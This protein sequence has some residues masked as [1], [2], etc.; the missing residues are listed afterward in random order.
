MSA[1]IG[2][3]ILAMWGLYHPDYIQ[4]KWHVFVIYIIMT[5]LCCALVMFGNR[6][7][8][9][10]QNIG[11]FVTVAGVVITVLVCAIMPSR[12][13]AGYASNAFVW[14][15]WDNQTGFSSNGFVFLA[16]LLNGAYSV[17][18]PDCVTHLA[19]EIPKP[20]VN[21]PKAI[22]AQMIVGAVTALVYLVAIFYAINSLDDILATTSSFPI[23][24]V[25]HQ[26]TNSN[27]GA[28]GLLLV[29][30]LPLIGTL[31][32]SYITVG[33]IL[34]TLARDD[35]TPLSSFLGRLDARQKNP[36]NATLACGIIVT[37]LG[38]IYLGSSTAFA[39]FVGSYVVLSTLSYLCAILPNLL[40]RR[41]YLP[42][43]PFRIPG[44]WGDVVYTLASVYIIVFIGIFCAPYALPVTAGSMNYT[45]VITVGSS[46]FVAALWVW[47]KSAGYVGPRVLL[48]EVVVGVD[49]VAA[50]DI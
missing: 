7:L 31:I 17:G 34:W 22:L 25:Y 28:L 45:S 11:S 14:K 37:V 23:A 35:A 6:A 38:C 41:R 27:G 39:A 36:R 48:E 50:C 26:A 29:I 21:I 13:G 10:V 12:T 8:P 46:L 5:W 49:S 2:N 18:T 4:Q 30:L 33:R 3:C 9:M 47:K 24:A 43:G 15:D 1:I 42:H 44:F 16:G 19:E 32:G 40:T 20:R